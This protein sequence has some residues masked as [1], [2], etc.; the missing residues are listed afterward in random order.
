[1]T[2]VTLTVI[3]N[4]M[5]EEE[6]DILA[7]RVSALFFMCSASIVPPLLQTLTYFG[8]VALLLFPGKIKSSPL[9][10]LV[11]IATACYVLIGRGVIDNHRYLIAYWAMV[12]LLVS[13]EKNCLTLLR[14]NARWIIGLVFC[15]ATVWKFIPGEFLNGVFF[16]ASYLTDFRFDF[17][18]SLLGGLSYDTIQA[19]RNLVDLYALVP[20]SS[21]EAVI[22]TKSQVHWFALLSS[23]WTILIEGSIGIFFVSP[24]GSLLYRHRH[25]T[26]I[27]F[28]LTTYFLAPVHTFGSLLAVLG[29]ISCEKEDERNRVIYLAVFMTFIF[30]PLLPYLYRHLS[31]WF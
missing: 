15:F 22:T 2:G 7:L 9:W 28:L 19:N 10:S 8:C 17:H 31:T 12:C 21:T 16:H 27:T 1:M 11:F 4:E 23:Y 26:L 14:H 13:D 18:A 29:L 24:K 25:K 20:G 6:W 5:K 3:K 30:L